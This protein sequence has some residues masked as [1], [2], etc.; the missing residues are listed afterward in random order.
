MECCCCIY[1]A[2]N[3]A[4]STATN[5]APCAAI[6]AASYVA[7]YV[8]TNAATNLT[9]TAKGR[10]LRLQLQ[11]ERRAKLGTPEAPPA[12]STAPNAPPLDFRS[13]PTKIAT[14]DTP[15]CHI[16]EDTNMSKHL[17]WFAPLQY[18]HNQ[19]PLKTDVPEILGFLRS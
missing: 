13:T 12:G 3:V 7:T 18:V 8:A 9:P 15:S 17:P 11:R 4:S 19:Q 14:A 16:A 10:R 6:F 2:T 5:P 1:A